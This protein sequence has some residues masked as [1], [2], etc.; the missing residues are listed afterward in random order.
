MTPRPLAAGR[1]LAARTPLQ[2]KLILAVLA[3]VAVAL[4]LI[5]LASVAA[6]DGYLVGRLDTQLEVV[7]RG[8]AREAPPPPFTG[9]GPSRKGPPSPYLVQYRTADGRLKNENKNPLEEG[10][11]SPRVPDDAAWFEANSGEVVTVPA[12]GGDGRWRVA[13]QPMRDGSDGSVLVAASLDGIDATTRQLRTIDLVVS[14]VVLLL[15]AGLGVL[16][17]R[18]S[19]RRWSRSSRRP[20]RSPAAT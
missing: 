10:Q 13:L 17:I 20:G 1:R 9:P 8:A 5:G 16:I 18:A 15:L 2:V 4:A 7:A 19:L 3:L 12:T 14:L 6:L 11:P